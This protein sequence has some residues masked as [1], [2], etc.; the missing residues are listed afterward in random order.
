MVAAVAGASAAYRSVAV[1][2]RDGTKLLVNIG[3]G[4]TAGVDGGMLVFSCD[5]GRV[6]LP[7]DEVWRWT[8]SA[9][10]GDDAVWSGISGAAVTDVV[11]TREGGNLVLRNLAKGERVA[12]TAADGAVVLSGVA[13]DGVFTV[14]A[15][16]LPAG[17]YIVSYGSHAVKILLGR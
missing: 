13:A 16:T 10:A 7:C 8:F 12:V 14:P 3:E 6:S 11:L 17:V 1:E 4:M 9:E 15:E 5:K 2:R